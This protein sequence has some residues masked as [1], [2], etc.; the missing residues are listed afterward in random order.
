[1]SIILFLLLTC[2]NEINTAK[3]LKDHKDYN[4]NI[5]FYKQTYKKHTNFKLDKIINYNNKNLFGKSISFSNC[6]ENEKY[7]ICNFG[8]G[9][10]YYPLVKIV[11][12]SIN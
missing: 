9:T 6:Y 4:N 5:I 2:Y 7:R 12:P 1:M 11:L 8:S 10:I 3:L